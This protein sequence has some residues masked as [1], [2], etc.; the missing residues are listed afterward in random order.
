[1]PAR[2]EKKMAAIN[3][4]ANPSAPVIPR[5][6]PGKTH[7]QPKKSAFKSS[8]ATME[9]MHLHHVSPDIGDDAHKHLVLVSPDSED[10]KAFALAHASAVANGDASGAKK[11]AIHYDKPSPHLGNMKHLVLISPDKSDRKGFTLSPVNEA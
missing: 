6:R 10:S 4:G 9:T 7:K 8:I 5:K 2:P 3:E 1:M 11:H